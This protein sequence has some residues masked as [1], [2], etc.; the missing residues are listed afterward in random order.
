MNEVPFNNKP[1]VLTGIPTPG[2]TPGDDKWHDSTLTINVEEWRNAAADTGIT[3]VIRHDTGAA[4]GQLW[5][6]INPDDTHID[7]PA[8][9]TASFI[10]EPLGGG[11]H[12][13]F[14]I[15]TP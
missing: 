9:K 12:G 11:V 10:D 3:Y 13:P 5:W 7:D 4:S 6:L 8:K 14:G 1:L 2:P 15:D